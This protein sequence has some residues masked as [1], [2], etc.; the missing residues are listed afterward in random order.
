MKILV[1]GASGLIGTALREKLCQD[2][3]SITCQS[4]HSYEPL[5]GI[6]WIK[7]DLVSDSWEAMALPE[8]DMVFHLAGQTSTYKAQNDPLADLSANL[9]GLVRLLD[10][11]RTQRKSP[12]VLLAGTVTQAGVTDKFTISEELNDKPIT[13]YDLSKLTAEKYLLQYIKEGWVNGCVLRFA[14]VFGRYNSEQQSDRG[15][16]DKIYRL[17][18]KGERITIY[19]DGLCF[20]DYIFIDDVISSMLITFKNKEN[21]NGRSF[22][23]GTG[24]KTTV[25][26]AFLE[27]ISIA[28]KNTGFRVSYENSSPPEYFSEIEFRNAVIDSSAFTQATGWRPKYDFKTGIWEAYGHKILNMNIKT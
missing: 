6:D 19:G 5:L 13:F 20:R 12:F 24:I 25:K 2:G 14:N 11:L 7:H 28:E 27:V 18:V 16:I 23:I 3:H 22:C 1:T 4:R 26:D 9:L 8:F 15:I 21:T 17:A 10:Y